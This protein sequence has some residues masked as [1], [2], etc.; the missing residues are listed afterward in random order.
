MMKYIKDNQI[1]EDIIQN[2]KDKIEQYFS[3]IISFL[4]EKGEILRIFHINN[5]KNLIE[6]SERLNINAENENSFTINDFI[7]NYSNILIEKLF[8]K[9]FHEKVFNELNETYLYFIFQIKDKNVV[10]KI[11]I[12]IYKYLYENNDLN[13]FIIKTCEEIIHNTT[14]DDSNLKKYK[15]LYNEFDI[16]I[17]KVQDKVLDF[18][19]QNLKKDTHDILNFFDPKKFIL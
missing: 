19:G 12:L 3:D 1:K 18:F 4:R 14:N 13:Q 16:N 5:L 11:K 6:E 15:L 17:D 10:N 7:V 2:K 9:D 8:N